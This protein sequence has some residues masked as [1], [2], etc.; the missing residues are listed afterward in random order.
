MFH[1]YKY[2]LPQTTYGY[3]ID[4]DGVGR[5]DYVSFMRSPS[6]TSTTASLYRLITQ[7]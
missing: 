6:L 3:A 2:N 7:K 1:G 4:I 5:L